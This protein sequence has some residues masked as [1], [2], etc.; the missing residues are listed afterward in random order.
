[1][2]LLEYVLNGFARASTRRRRKEIITETGETVRHVHKARKEAKIY[3]T[4]LKRAHW[5]DSSRYKGSD[6]VR[7]AKY[8]IN[9]RRLREAGK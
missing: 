4:P 3:T 6:I 2:N 5:T 1:M 7:L 8:G 9:A